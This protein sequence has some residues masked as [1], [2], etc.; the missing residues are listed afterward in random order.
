MSRRKRK[1]LIQ[2]NGTTRSDFQV[3]AYYDSQ[4]NRLHELLTV[5]KVARLVRVDETT[6]RR[7][8][9]QQGLE[10][11]TLPHRSVRQAYRIHLSTIVALLHLLEGETI[12]LLTV[13]SVAKQL[14]VDET[15]VRR[16]IKDHV[17]EAVALPHVGTRVA[18]RVKRGTLQKLL[19]EPP[20]GSSS[21]EARAM[22]R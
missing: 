10:V 11:V 2:S 1:E 16:W 15:T 12:D 18:Y 17:L 8:I 22:Q 20:L 19:K 14:R 13:K 21:Q 9:V 5:A 7:W 3:R 6:V 4:G